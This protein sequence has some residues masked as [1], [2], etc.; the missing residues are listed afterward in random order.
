[1]GCEVDRDFIAPTRLITWRPEDLGDHDRGSLAPADADS[2]VLAL[3]EE[4]SSGR[5]DD[6]NARLGGELHSKWRSTSRTEDRRGSGRTIS[7]S[8]TSCGEFFLQSPL[9]GLVTREERIGNGG[10]EFVQAS[11]GDLARPSPFGFAHR[12]ARS[13]A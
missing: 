3:L 2:A 12:L 1:A 8:S 6:R 9:V 13:G 11:R 10:H 5:T 7:P 4:G